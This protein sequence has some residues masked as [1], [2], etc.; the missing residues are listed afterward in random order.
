MKFENQ[1]KSGF[2]GVEGL[3]IPIIL[4]PLHPPPWPSPSVAA[5]P[6]PAAAANAHVLPPVSTS[7]PSPLPDHLGVFISNELIMQARRPRTSPT[8]AV[9]PTP[10]PTTSSRP[11]PSRPHVADAQTKASI[12]FL[13]LFLLHFLIKFNL[14]AIYVQPTRL[15]RTPSSPR[16]PR[17]R[18]AAPLYHVHASPTPKRRQVLCF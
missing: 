1:K 3:P 7:P 13:T 10:A 17:R 6:P 4:L 5:A 12:M 15:P 9:Q 11:P 2:F 16:R 8:H 14:S 18:L